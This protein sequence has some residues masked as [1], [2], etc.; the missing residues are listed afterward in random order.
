MQHIERTSQ[1]Q[2]I[3]KL[4]GIGFLTV[5][6]FAKGAPKISLSRSLTIDLAYDQRL[7][8]RNSSSFV[9]FG[10]IFTSLLSVQRRSSSGLVR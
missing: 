3:D 1:G 2:V 8:K 5:I 4:Q 9:R 10:E 7:I 6:E